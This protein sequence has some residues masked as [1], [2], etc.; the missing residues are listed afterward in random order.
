[1]DCDPTCNQRGALRDEETNARDD[2]RG[3]NAERDAFLCAVV[4][5]D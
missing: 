3:N 2:G 4:G 5:L 1:M